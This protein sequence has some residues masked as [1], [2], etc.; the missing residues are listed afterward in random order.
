M[1]TV[2]KF[3]FNRAH[4]TPSAGIYPR[5]NLPAIVLSFFF[6]H[7]IPSLFFFSQVRS[8]DIAII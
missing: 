5:E 7:F 2:G 4:A 8:F 6:H 3:A 1:L